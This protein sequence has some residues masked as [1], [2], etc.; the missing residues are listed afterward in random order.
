MRKVISDPRHV[1]NLVTEAP[2]FRR[3][4][5]LGRIGQSRVGTVWGN[6]L[7]EIRWLGSTGG[8]VRM[9]GPKCV[10]GEDDL[11]I[12][13][14]S[15]ASGFDEAATANNFWR[16][17]Q[18]SRQWN[19]V[20]DNHTTNEASDLYCWWLFIRC[21]AVCGTGMPCLIEQ[22]TASSFARG[23]AKTTLNDDMFLCSWWARSFW[24][25]S[26]VN[27]EA[28]ICYLLGLKDLYLREG[29]PSDRNIRDS[30]TTP[31][32][33]SKKPA[34]LTGLYIMQYLRR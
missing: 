15:S 21:K 14:R 5:Y 11:P 34:R 24:S 23:S 27:D 29:W 25:W 31:C 12:S 9:N 7:S 3:G 8:V 17:R 4:K 10:R 19:R 6:C 18:L 33:N 30:L 13:R 28:P 26:D 20:P 22:I 16:A 1:D 2:L 32:P